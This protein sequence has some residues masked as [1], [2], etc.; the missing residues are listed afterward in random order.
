[1]ISFIQAQ[2]AI[3]KYKTKYFKLYNDSVDWY[4]NIGII[5]KVMYEKYIV[6]IS[7]SQEKNY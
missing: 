2:I 5:F 7:Y 4:R 6:I 3:I 1:M